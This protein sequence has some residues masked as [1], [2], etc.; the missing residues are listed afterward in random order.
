MIFTLKELTKDINS[1]DSTDILSSWHWLIGEIKGVHTIT[2]LGDLFL[3]GKDDGIY[4]LQ[5]DFGELTKVAKNNLQFQKLLFDE[6]KLDEWFLPGLVE[7]L[8]NAG[9]I[10]KKNEIYSYKILPVLGGDYSVE[11]IKPTDISV[12]FAFCGDICEQIKDLPNGT[13]INI[14]VKE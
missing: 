7:K 8:I 6:E 13:K 10:L 1:V 11:N 4:W 14:V 12:H 2:V 5:S 3:I 9:K